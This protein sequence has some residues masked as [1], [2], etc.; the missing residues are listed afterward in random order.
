M[1]EEDFN[2]NTI[3][4]FEED[5]DLFDLSIFD[6]L[7]DMDL[8][9]LDF[10]DDNLVDQMNDPTGKILKL[11]DELSEDI[12]I[13]SIEEDLNAEV[14]DAD[15]KFVNYVSLFQK[16]YSGITPSDELYDKDYIEDVLERVTK[17]ALD[18]LQ[19]KYGI[20]MGVDLDFANPAEYLKDVSTMY[21]F[22]F[23]RNFRNVCD[24]ISK[25]LGKMTITNELAKYKDA[26]DNGDFQKD[27]FIINDKKK[28][29]N[30][31]DALVV[32]FISDIMEDIREEADSG[33]S[34]FNEITGFDMFEDINYEF[35]NLLFE[36][37]NKLVFNYDQETAKKYFAI[38]DDNEV[39][40][41][42][43]NT[44]LLKYLESAELTEE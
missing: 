37:G 7:D 12:I 16:K 39:K 22:L 10:S 19:A 25:R 17:V 44:V 36:Y 42:I 11:S 34:L 27:I 32:N 20:E 31:K 13:E 40:S 26:V 41:K 1:E 9:D 30:E 33:Y 28:F 2:F 24:Y 35:S 3:P 21:E 43:R 6:D 38:M 15:R 29:V 14:Y 23:I 18:G 5:D 8:F 4:L